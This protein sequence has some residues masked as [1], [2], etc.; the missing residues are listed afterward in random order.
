MDYTKIPRVLIYKDRTNLS[1]FRVK[2]DDTLNSQ[3][4]II[5]RRHL[6]NNMSIA[7]YTNTILWLFNESYYLTTMI[8]LDK[9]AVDHFDDYSNCIYIDSQ[10]T[11]EKI[12]LYKK[13]ICAMVYVFLNH[14]SDLSLEL[15]TVRRFL[16][17]E[18]LDYIDIFSELNNYT[19][20]GAEEFKPVRITKDLLRN[21]DWKKITSDYKLDNIIDIIEEIGREKAEKRLLI[22]SIFHSYYFSGNIYLISYS[23]DKYLL[24]RYEELGGN[25]A[26]LTNYKMNDESE[27]G[28]DILI[29]QLV[30]EKKD[31]QNKIYKIQKEKEELKDK[32][33][34]LLSQ[35]DK[36][37]K[38]RERFTLSEAEHQRKENELQ[39][40]LEEVNGMVDKFK[41]KLGKKTV[42][43]KVIADGIRKKANTIGLN[44]A[45]T[46]FEQINL[47]LY[48]VPAWRDNKSELDAFFAEERKRI[49][50]GIR[51]ESYGQQTVI[52]NVE[53]YKPLI[54]TQNIGMSSLPFGQQDIKHLE[55][56]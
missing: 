21:I 36:H 12:H 47:I 15:R 11:V 52:P 39:R 6:Y 14:S 27:E 8:L 53:N 17:N 44:E 42:S 24:T 37:N 23:V 56:E 7:R 9:K 35:I 5:L 3:L 40:Q 49:N 26:S 10:Y 30:N 43:L 28:K 34:F 31:L 33:N 48:D 45:C 50:N 2:D 32:V 54:D 13:M 20:P 51:I 22:K 29:K 1:E 16:R 38:V 18:A 55:D 4:Y 25:K 19:K 46:L 41:D